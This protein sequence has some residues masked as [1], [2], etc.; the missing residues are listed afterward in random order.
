VNVAFISS[1]A[2]EYPP[3]RCNVSAR[4]LPGQTRK[5]L[6]ILLYADSAFWAEAESEYAIQRG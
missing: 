6:A 1:F 2:F 5:R 3:G 4:G